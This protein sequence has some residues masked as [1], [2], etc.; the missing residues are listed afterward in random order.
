VLGSVDIRFPDQSISEEL[1]TV[2]R[3]LNI[4][5]NPNDELRSWYHRVLTLPEARYVARQVCWV[6]TVER[7]PAYYL[8]LCC[9]AD[10]ND[11]AKCLGEPQDDDLCLFVG[12]SSLIPVETSPGVTAPVLAVDQLCSFK[13]EHLVEWCKPPKTLAKRKATSANEPGRTENGPSELFHRLVQSADNFGDTDER[14]A[15][16]Y[17]A[18]RYQPLYHLYAQML[19]DDY[20]LDSIKVMKSRLWGEKRILDPVFTFANESGGVRK[21]FV[22]VDVTYLFPMIAN[23]IAEYFDR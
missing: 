14:R 3:T 15:L 2:A 5:Q 10:L 11:L 13:K 18:V 17:L 20:I 1:Q 21:Y 7:Q 4:V 22:R 16:N 6:L 19:H 8:A 9:P 12:S 23:K